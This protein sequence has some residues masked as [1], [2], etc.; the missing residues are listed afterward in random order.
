MYVKIKT[1][2]GVS[3]PV[4]KTPG[5]AGMDISA[6]EFHSIKPGDIKVVKTGVYLQLPIGYEAQIRTRSGMAL[7][8]LIVLNSPGTIDS[9]YRGEVGVIIM[10]VSK[11]NAYINKGDRIA[12]MVI[13]KHE[14]V[15]WEIVDR[16]SETKRGGGGYGSTGV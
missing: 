1:D 8:G 10:N 13:A 7:D 15:S 11:S 14:N 5:S 9:D 6:N 2:E 16:L 12:Q 3:L 4:Y